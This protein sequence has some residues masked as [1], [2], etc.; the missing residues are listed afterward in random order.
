M[1]L[2]IEKKMVH[3]LLQH[4][5]Y[6]FSLY[7]RIQWIPKRDV[8]SEFLTGNRRSKYYILLIASYLGLLQIA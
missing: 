3:S 2:A 1:R 6:N 7:K 5:S 4:P 8:D